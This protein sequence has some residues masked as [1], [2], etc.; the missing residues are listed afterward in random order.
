LATGRSRRAIQRLRRDGSSVRVGA[1]IGGAAVSGFIRRAWVHIGV[2]PHSYR[3]VGLLCHRI[4]AAVV[5]TLL[6]H[7]GVGLDSN[8]D[9]HHV[10]GALPLPCYGSRCGAGLGSHPWVDGGDATHECCGASASQ[11]RVAQLG[12]SCSYGERGRTVAG[13]RAR[14]LGGK[15]A[16]QPALHRK[17]SRLVGDNGKPSGVSWRRSRP[18]RARA[19]AGPSG[20]FL[21]SS[22]RDVCDRPIVLRGL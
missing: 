4:A 6:R 22:T 7:P 8:R 1:H 18:P 2:A 13:C 16:Q 14:R 3:G 5:H 9:L 21:D 19:A 17:S 10:V 15:G 20:R 12:F 11:R